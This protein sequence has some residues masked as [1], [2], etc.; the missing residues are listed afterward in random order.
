MTSVF[1]SQRLLFRLFTEEDAPLV[2]LLNSDPEVLQYVH[3][4]PTDTLEKAMANLCERILPQYQ[5]Y[6]YG[7]WAVFT[8]DDNRFIGWCGLKFRPERNEIDLG[9]RFVKSA[10]GKGYATEAA[11]A[12]LDYGFH[13]L[14][15][16]RIVA[17]AQTENLASIR[18]IGK[19]GFQFSHVDVIEGFHVKVFQLENTASVATN[20]PKIINL[21]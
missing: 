18:V 10:W 2:Q 20:L 5:L 16:P 6:G 7:R 17:V 11:K 1:E 15:I 9:Y 8:K 4:L 3:E 12:T 14:H 19:C 13:T 21:F